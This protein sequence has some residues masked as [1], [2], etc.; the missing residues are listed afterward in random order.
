MPGEHMLGMRWMTSFRVF[1][2]TS[3]GG[4]ET[5]GEWVGGD[6]GSKQ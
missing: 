6:D 2:A 5:V 3:A 1:F 4:G